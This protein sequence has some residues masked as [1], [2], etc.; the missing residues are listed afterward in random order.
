MFNED[1]IVFRYT[2]DGAIQDGILVDV[3]NP[4]KEAGFSIP[5]G[6]DGE[7]VFGVRLLA[8]NERRRFRT[9][10]GRLWDVLYMAAVACAR[11]REARPPCTKTS[12]IP[13]LCFSVS[14]RRSTLCVALASSTSSIVPGNIVRPPFATLRIRS[15][16]RLF[17]SPAG[18]SPA[19]ASSFM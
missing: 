3:S 7:S 9:E 4:A 8:G 1:D 18:N 16:P 12:Q 13:D 5:P 11:C 17:D 14:E 6:A 2:R 19:G 10:N 15:M